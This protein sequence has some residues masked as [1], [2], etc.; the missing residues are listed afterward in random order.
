MFTGWKFVLEVTK[1][2]NKIIRFPTIALV[3]VSVINGKLTTP[4]VTSFD[5]SYVLIYF[6]LMFLYSFLI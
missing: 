3:L 5:L 2:V 6:N 1:R 4:T